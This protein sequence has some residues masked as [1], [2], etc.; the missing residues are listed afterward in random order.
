MNC[1]RAFTVP[2]H[3]T[4]SIRDAMRYAN[5]CKHS[6][7]EAFHTHHVLRKCSHPRRSGLNASSKPATVELG[8]ATA[9]LR[10]GSQVGLRPVTSDDKPLL[11]SG[12]SRLSPRARYLRFLAPAERLSAGQLAYLSEIDHHDHVAWGVLDGDDAAAVGRWVRLDDEPW[13]ADV[14]VTVLDDYQRRGIGR[15]L[16]EV[17][18]VS[19]RARGV[20]VFHFD[21]LAENDAMLGL[22]GSLGAVR[23]GQNGVV[24]LVLDVSRVRPPDVV[25]GD[26]IGLLEAARRSAA[27]RVSPDRARD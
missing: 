5:S 8:T 2:K 16:L 1:S 22:L 18:A 19:A 26:L 3:R 7:P 17:L 21:V 11:L 9:I 25:D 27:S 6:D 15:M 24:H 20:G 13:A 12:F 14:A 10:D 23:T 4:G